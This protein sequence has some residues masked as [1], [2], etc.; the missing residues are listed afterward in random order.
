MSRTVRWTQA[1]T[2]LHLELLSISAALV[3]QLLPCPSLSTDLS[4][5]V[6][7]PELCKKCVCY[8]LLDKRGFSEVGFR[9]MKQKHRFRNKRK[10]G[11]TD[12]SDTIWNPE[13]LRWRVSY[14]EVMTLT[15]FLTSAP[16]HSHLLEASGRCAFIAI[17]ERSNLCTH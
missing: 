16:D 2:G 10:V 1:E 6:T 7:L 5:K 4:P 13:H 9:A 8:H 17:T 3:K 11:L 14:G 12:F 15:S